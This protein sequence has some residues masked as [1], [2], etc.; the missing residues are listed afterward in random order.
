MGRTGLDE[1][2]TQLRALPFV[3]TAAAGRARADGSVPLSL[4]TPAGKVKFD[5]RPPP[6]PQGRA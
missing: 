3:K 1:Y 5:P 6:R 2:L 4:S